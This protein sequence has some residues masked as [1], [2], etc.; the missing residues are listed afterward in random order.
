MEVHHH[1]HVKKKN[2]KEYF[3]EFIMI[4]PAVT[5]GFFAEQMREY[6]ADTERGKEYMQEI[7]QN[8]EYD[9]VRCSLNKQSNIIILR[10]LDSLR[11]Q[12]KNAVHG[13][14]PNALYYFSHYTNTV[15]T[16]V[17]NTSA[18]TELKSSG[19]LRLIP[20]KKLVNELSDYYERK[21][22]ATNRFTTIT[23]DLTNIENNIF[24]LIDLDDVIK[25][26]DSV[27]VSTY[28]VD[29][30][31]QSILN[32]K[33]ELTLLSSD[34]ILFEKCIRKLVHWKYQ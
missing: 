34:P 29:Y 32:H 24:S 19:S 5:Q 30:N 23:T 10:V 27:Q 28:A 6:F 13:Y 15:G 9:T 2:F 14:N 16:A 8:L 21:L 12:I 31:Y 18:I 4:F 25:A 20:N 3:F 7:V 22:S 26:Y 33:P 1:P 11:A 17:F